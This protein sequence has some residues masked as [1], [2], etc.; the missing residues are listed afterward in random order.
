M[1]GRNLSK[2]GDMTMMSMPANTN[3]PNSFEARLNT[4]LARADRV[5]SE[6]A[7]LAAALQADDR[8]SRGR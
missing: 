8:R 5:R 2:N 4:M 3:S 6:A 7:M 1:M